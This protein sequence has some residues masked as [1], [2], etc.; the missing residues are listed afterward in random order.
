LPTA[1]RTG[2]I[3]S[4]PHLPHYAL[5]TDDAKLI[6]VLARQPVEMSRPHPLTEAG[7]R[8]FSTF[9]WMPPSGAQAGDIVLVDLKMFTTLFTDGECLAETDSA[10]I[11]EA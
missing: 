4:H 2:Q 3:N 9:L 8:E 1:W 10:D 6:R 7:N 5:T 11:A